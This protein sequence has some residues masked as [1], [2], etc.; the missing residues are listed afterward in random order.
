MTFKPTVL[1]ADRHRELRWHGRLLVPGLFDGEHYFLIE[2]KAVGLTRLVHGEKFSGL[3][4]AMARSTL[5]KGTRDGFIVMNK[6]LKTRAE[7][8][9]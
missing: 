5:D 8:G 7:T 4:V 6:A 9:T 3:P 2:G 1:V